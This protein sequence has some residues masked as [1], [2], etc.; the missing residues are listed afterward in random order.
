MR[1]ADDTAVWLSHGFARSGFCCYSLPLSFRNRPL[2]APRYLTCAE[3]HEYLT[4]PESVGGTGEGRRARC[5][6][7]FKQSEKRGRTG[8]QLEGFDD[9]FPLSL[10][11]YFF[12]QLFLKQRVP[13][14][15]RESTWS[16]IALSASLQQGWLLT[17]LAN[18]VWFLCSLERGCSCFM[19]SLCLLS[20]VRWSWCRAVLRWKK[21]NP[22]ITVL[23]RT[24]HFAN[25][26][27]S[28]HASTLGDMV[29]TFGEGWC[30]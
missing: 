29:F 14:P 6:V 1:T 7:G 23:Q 4:L 8:Q 13:V 16:C 30:S 9:I 24:S 15:V 22:N 12:L 11:Y 10:L 20:Q 5:A 18:H 2:I 26:L 21:P 17:R 25:T 28:R 27:G 3:D 19:F